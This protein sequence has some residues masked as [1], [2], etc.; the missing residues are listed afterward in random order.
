MEEYGNDDASIKD[1]LKGTLGDPA[2]TARSERRG[3]DEAGEKHPKEPKRTPILGRAGVGEVRIRDRDAV[4]GRIRRVRIHMS[5]TRR[6]PVGNRGTKRA[7]VDGQRAVP[8]I[9]GAP[10][11]VTLAV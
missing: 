8:G 1:K 3:D 7:A 6:G 10:I 11:F 9:D 5:T 2:G 4:H